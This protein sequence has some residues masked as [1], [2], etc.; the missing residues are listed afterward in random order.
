[1]VFMVSL[2]RTRGAFEG[3]ASRL[4]EPI[5]KV[6]AG[7]LNIAVV[8]NTAALCFVRFKVRMIADQE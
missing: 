1:M 8:A 2:L 4:G 3:Q 6:E 5:A 7:A